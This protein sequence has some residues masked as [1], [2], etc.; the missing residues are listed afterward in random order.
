MNIFLEPWKKR[1]DPVLRSLVDREEDGEREEEPTN[2][3][4]LTPSVSE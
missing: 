3:E 4:C 1:I 2:Q